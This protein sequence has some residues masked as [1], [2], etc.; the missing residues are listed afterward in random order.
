M[1]AHCCFIGDVQR[2]FGRMSALDAGLFIS[3]LKF[4]LLLFI[5]ILA[6]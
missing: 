2:G 1:M 5:S 4:I 6:V 3:R